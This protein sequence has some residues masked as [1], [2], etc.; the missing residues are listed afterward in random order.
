MRALTSGAVRA[1]ARATGCT[2]DELRAG[3]L[4]IADELTVRQGVELLDGTSHGAPIELDDPESALRAVRVHRLG[5]L[6]A[7]VEELAR[8]GAET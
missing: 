5:A 3:L 1:G 6:I 7:A 4:A 2:E 8:S